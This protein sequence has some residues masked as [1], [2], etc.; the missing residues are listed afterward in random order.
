MWI[1]THC[2]LDAPEL[3]VMGAGLSAWV[4]ASSALDSGC[5]LSSEGMQYSSDRPDESLVPHLRVRQV[6]RKSGVA[7]CVLP[8]VEVG[9]FETVRQLA[10][11]CGDAYALGIHPLYVPR[12]REGDLDR[13]DEQLTAHRDDPRL[14]AVG[15]IG[16]DFFV[17]ALCTADMRARQQTVY[18]AQLK[19]ARKH[20]LPVLLHVRRSAD[21]LLKHLREAWGLRARQTLPPGCA[22]IAHAF[23]GSQAQA[24]AF[25]SL[26]FK[27]GFGGTV[28]FEA[29]R[30]IRH[31]A[32]S[33][34]A[35]VPVMETD[36]PD[37][38]PQWLYTTASQREEGKPQGV[39]TPAEL[40]RMGAVV[41][42]LRGISAADWAA[43]TTAN[44]VAALPR[45]ATLLAGAVPSGVP[46]EGVGL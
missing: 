39:N 13:L 31:L 11:S 26:G 5:A 6:A 28:T 15:E 14:V 38:P 37:I 30:Q 19:L 25:V 2:H 45:L 18:R 12:M 1:D 4:T 32:A 23:N 44:A 9:N 42:D 7:L 21:L 24:N 27:L 36:A 34:P 22:G 46:T 20:G 17:P 16:L 33:L 43:Q 8:A 3:R 41:A 10:H 29:S 35:H 40:P